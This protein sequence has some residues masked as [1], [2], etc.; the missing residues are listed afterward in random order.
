MKTKIIFSKE[1]L[2]Y[3][4]WQIE[5][6]ERVKLTA[7]ILRKKGY[8]FLEPKKALKKELLLVHKESYLKAIKKRKLEDED[9]LA[10][11]N[12]YEYASLSAGAAILA[13][14]VGGFS[15]MRPPGHHA[16][17]AGLALGAPTRG[18]CYFNNIAI[19]VKSLN[20]PT[21]IL[22][23][24]GHH[25]NGTEN[26]FFGDKNITFISLHRRPDYPWTGLKSR[27][28]CLNFPLPFDCGEQMY[29][30]TLDKALKKVDLSKIMVVAVSVGFDTHKKGLASLGLT[31]KTFKIIGR[32]IAEL[33]KHTFFVLEGGYNAK[34]VS[35]DICQLLSS[36]ELTKR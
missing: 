14:K 31:S 11:K 8:N 15:L 27:G 1:C 30:K 29:L 6:P 18:F 21:L 12:I 23:I 13:A 2:D 24:D 5:G 3:G 17:S 28:N 36:Y 26:I 20:K 19:A 10:Y 7:K 22:D 9:S 16:G 33:N 25:G 4:I 34:D 35:E 32:K